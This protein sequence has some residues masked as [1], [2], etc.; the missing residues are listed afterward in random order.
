[1]L[2]VAN[3]VVYNWAAGLLG[4]LRRTNPHLP[5]LVVPFDANLRR[6]PRLLDRLGVPLHQ[7]T[8]SLE[9]AELVARRCGGDPGMFRRL[10]AFDG[11]FDLTLYLDTDTVVLRSLDPLFDAVAASGLDVAFGGAKDA[12]RP[13]RHYHFRPGPFL[14]HYL[15]RGGRLWNAGVIMASR[16]RHGTGDMARFAERLGEVR[17]SFAPRC[18]DQSFICHYLLEAQARAATLSEVC[19]ASGT[20]VHQPVRRTMAGPVREAGGRPVFVL[21]WA[22]YRGPYPH[23]PL[24]SFWAPHRLRA[25]DVA[26]AL[27][28]A[29]RQRR[30]PGDPGLPRRLATGAVRLG[31]SRHPG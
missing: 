29:W 5:V 11:P 28:G 23:M 16:G 21:H 19:G 18:E 20:S 17:S 14:D 12:P 22:G 3:D 8:A 25:G 24:V 6:L 15:A 26:G 30:P 10:V 31:R 2:T 13:G 1:V 9:A 4:S 27:L 7:P